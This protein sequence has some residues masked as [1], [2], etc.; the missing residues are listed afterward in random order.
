MPVVEPRLDRCDFDVVGVFRSS[1]S[2]E[3]SQGIVP[4]FEDL[5]DVGTF[6]SLVFNGRRQC[7]SFDSLDAH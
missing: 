2:Y 3:D 7:H 6:W 5:D 4:K 1:S